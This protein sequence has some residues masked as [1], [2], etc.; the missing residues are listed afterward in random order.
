[1]TTNPP[2]PSQPSLPSSVLF[3]PVLSRI[4]LSPRMYSTI[5]LLA[6]TMKRVAVACDGKYSRSTQDTITRTLCRMVSSSS[7]QL[8]WR[9]PLETQRTQ[10]G[11]TRHIRGQRSWVWLVLKAPFTTGQTLPR[12]ARRRIISSGLQQLAHS[13]TVVH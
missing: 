9:E 2:G 13:C 10:T 5:K 11:R 8:D 7:L 3:P 6:G 12:I 1:M 4:F